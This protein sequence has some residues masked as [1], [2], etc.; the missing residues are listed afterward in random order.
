MHEKRLLWFLGAVPEISG[1]KYGCSIAYSQTLFLKWAEPPCRSWFSLS[2]LLFFDQH[3]KFVLNREGGKYVDCNTTHK[4]VSAPTNRTYSHGGAWVAGDWELWAQMRPCK[5]VLKTGKSK[6]EIE[7]VFTMKGTQ[8]YTQRSDLHFSRIPNSRVEPPQKWVMTIDAIWYSHC[9]LHVLF[10]RQ[11]NT[12]LVPPKLMGCMF[13][14]AILVMVLSTAESMVLQAN[15]CPTFSTSAAIPWSV[16][17]T[18]LWGGSHRGCK[19]TFAGTLDWSLP[20]VAS[21]F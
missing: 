3:A 9:T 18:L 17:W 16:C 13:I 8:G 5:A 12:A 15:F 10:P 4:L 6:E 21:F 20:L 19:G 1:T 14:T 7:M 11:E 2:C